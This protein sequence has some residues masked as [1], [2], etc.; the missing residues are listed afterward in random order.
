[1]CDRK[2]GGFWP[3]L[4]HFDVTIDLF[5]W[6]IPLTKN[7]NVKKT[8]IHTPLSICLKSLNFKIYETFSN[9]IVINM[10]TFCSIPGNRRKDPSSHGK[11]SFLLIIYRLAVS[12]RLLC[13]LFTERACMIFSNFKF[14]TS[15]NSKYISEVFHEK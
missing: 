13:F 12:V 10:A 11:A 5:L 15:N 8:E 2:H 9:K 14:I 6:R 3:N 4:R 7:T 1:M